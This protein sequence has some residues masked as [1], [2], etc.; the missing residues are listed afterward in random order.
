MKKTLTGFA[1]IVVAALWMTG[2]WVLFN[3]IAI[4]AE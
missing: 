2:S 4:G 1:I 3:S